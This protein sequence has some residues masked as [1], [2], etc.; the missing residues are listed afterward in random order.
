MAAKRIILITGAN[1]GIG[2]DASYSVAAASPSNHVIMG[3]RSLAKGAKALEELQERKPAGTLSVLELDVTNDD[4]IKAAAEKISADFGVLDALVNNAGVVVRGSRDRRAELLDT[5]N[6]NTVGPFVLTEALL[7]LLRKSKDPRIINV[8]SAIGSI[9]IRLDPSHAS[10]DLPAEA[11]RMSKAALN[12]ATAC[13]HAA[14]SPWGAR[15]WA[16]CPGYV[17]TNL[18]GEGDRQRRRDSGAESSETSAAGI[19]E[20]LGGQRDGE[21]GSFLHRRGQQLPW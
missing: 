15:V 21:A 2:Y 9:S 3:C 20:I 13:M 14:Y 10:Y 16:Y 5:L 1:S 11:Y 12:M 19:L 17:V 4:T 7:P 18:T 6:T 8:S